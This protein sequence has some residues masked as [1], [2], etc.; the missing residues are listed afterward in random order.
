MKTQS[1]LQLFQYWN[2]LRG[3]LPAPK[4][5]QIE[6]FD[7]QDVLSQTF[8]LECGSHNCAMTF[9]LAGTAI[10]NLFCRPLRGDL[11]SELFE[12]RNRPVISRLM[13]NCYQNGSVVLLEL[14]AQSVSGRQ[15]L[16]ELIMLPLHDEP[17]GHRILGCIAPHQTQFWHGLEPV[18]HIDLYSIRIVDPN[19]DPLFLKNRPEVPIAP[20]LS[21]TESHVQLAPRHTGERIAQ[22]LVIEGGKFRSDHSKITK[23]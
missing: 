3:N 18:S 10:S 14:S 1:A 2:R 5:T 7:I 19:H 11:F 17:A 23:R 13:R 4:R 21:P 22:F 9:R 6:P 12:S 8:I 16:L 15:T 20:T